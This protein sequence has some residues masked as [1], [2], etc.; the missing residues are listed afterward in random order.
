METSIEPAV[1]LDPGLRPFLET[2]DEGACE[3]H[4]AALVTEVVEPV[5]RRVCRARL[6]GDDA[7]DAADVAASVVLGVLARLRSLRHAPEDV[8]IADFP[9]YVA[10]VAA[11][12]CR[13]LVRSRHPERYRLKGRVRYVLTRQPGFAAWPHGGETWCGFAVWKDT[14]RRA[15]PASLDR[16]RQ[17][18]SAHAHG[19]TL[20]DTLAR[21]FDH[22][23]GA[24]E[25]DELVDA[26]A[27]R[28]GIQDVRLVEAD[29]ANAVAAPSAQDPLA[30]RDEQAAIQR[31]WSEIVSLPL[32]QR[33]ALL[34]N[35]RDA[36]GRDAI[37]LFPSTGTAGVHEIAAALE[38]DAERLAE[39]WPR[40]PLPDAEIAVLLA[41]TRQQ[42]INL[43]K[44]AR[45]RLA[46]HLA[47]ASSPGG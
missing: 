12:A 46:R 25:L 16:L 41:V 28:L 19:E 14:P 34:L 45:E 39:L 17:E 10:K 18:T 15:T 7:R 26:V 23:G 44:C 24:L 35:L 1:L 42:V 13:D 9:S 36:D 32:R 38:M 21:V 43:R 30:A 4:L 5:A 3:G 40:L 2:A 8:A 22:A 6:R 11:N 31:L 27:R 33:T 47:S 29:E 37:A 20:P